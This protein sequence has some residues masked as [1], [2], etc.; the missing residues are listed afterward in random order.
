[1]TS[2]NTN[3][4]AILARTFATKANDRQRTS[5]ERLASGLRINSSADD[6][7]G[8]AVSTKMYSQIT[9]MNSALRNSMDGISLI[10]TAMSGMDTITNMVQRMRELAT[11][12]H[13]GVYTDTDRQNA[14]VEI[15]QLLDGISQI[16]NNTSFNEVSLLDGSYQNSIRAGHTNSE[17]INL[18]IDS[19]GILPFIKGSSTAKTLL[20]NTLLRPLTTASGPSLLDYLS[21]SFSRG[22]SVINIASQTNA[23][24]NSSFQTLENSTAAGASNIDFLAS[25]LATGTSNFITPQ[26]SIGSG[27][28]QIERSLS[29]TGSGSSAF[30]TPSATSG[31]GSSTLDLL[32]S[33]SPTGTSAFNALANSRASGSSQVD[34]LLS[35]TATGTSNFQTPG[36]STATGTTSLDI[37]S[38]TNGVNTSA[39]DTSGSSSADGV[40]GR[41][42]LANANASGN[43][44]LNVLSNS[45]PTSSSSAIAGLAASSTASVT[46]SSRI[47]PLLFENG[48]F[49]YG[50]SGSSTGTG[51]SSIVGW[52]I[53]LEQVNLGDSGQPVTNQIKVNGT[54]ISSPAD[55]GGG[56]DNALVQSDNGNPTTFSFNA[57]SG[58]ITLGTNSVRVPNANGYMHGPYITSKEAY[59]ISAGDQVYFDWGVNANGDAA[60]VYA[61]LVDTATN[62]TV[63]L[64]NYRQSSPGSKSI[65]RQTTTV[66][67]SGNYNFVFVSGSY[68][69]DGGQVLGS[70]L[71]LRDVGITQSNPGAAAVTTGT[72]TLAAQESNSVSIS[73]TQLAEL[74]KKAQLD[75]FNGSFQILQRGSDYNKFSIDQNGNVTSSTLQQSAKSNYSFEV[76]YNKSNGSGYHTETVNLNLTATERA[77]S[78]LVAQEGNNLTINRSDLSLLNSYVNS[79]SGGSF[80]FSSTSANANQFNIDVN[81]GQITS[82]TPLDFDVQKNYSFDV[83]FTRASDGTEFVNT[84][85]LTLTDTLDSVAALTSEEANRVQVANT[86]LSTIL[87]YSN[88]DNQA[89]TFSISGSDGGYFSVDNLGNVT[90]NQALLLATKGTYSFSVNYRGVNGITHTEN[91]TLGLT[92]ALQASSNLTANEATNVTISASKLSK[93][94]GFAARNGPGIYSI[95]QTGSDYN[96]FNVNSSTG[97]ITNATTLDP[98]VQSSYSFDLVF[99]SSSDGRQFIETVNL[100]IADSSSPTTTI[101]SAESDQ[102]TITAGTLLRSVAYATTYGGGAYSLSGS[103]ASK[104]NINSGTGEV[105]SKPG[106]TFRIDSTGVYNHQNQFDFN[107]VYTS[108]ANVH[109]EQIKLKITETLDTVSNVSAHESGQV[110]IAPSTLI[111][112]FAARD[113][114]QGSYQ[115]ASTGPDYAKFSI[116]SSTGNVVSTG[117]L[118][119]DTQPNYTFDVIY[120]SASDGRQFTETV[121]LAITDTLQSTA[122][123]SAEETQSLTIAENALTSTEFFATTKDGA[124]ESGSYNLSGAHAGLFSIAPDGAIT[125]NG[126]VNRGTYNFNVQYTAGTGA[127]HTESV[128]LNV[129]R[130]LQGSSAMSAQEATLVKI[131]KDDLLETRS[132]ATT[133]GSNGTYRFGTSRPDYQFFEFDAF[134]NIQSKAALDFDTQ[135]S[136]V[137]DVIYRASDGREYTDTVTLNLLDTLQSTATLTVEETQSLT[138]AE[139]TLTSTEH[140]ATTKDGAGETGTYALSGTHSNLF[141]V[142]ADGAITSTGTVNK[143]TY[144]FNVNY[145]DGNGVT[146]VEAVTLNVTEALQSSSTLSAAEA[147]TVG[148]NASAMSNLADF[149]SRHSGGSYRLA[150]TGDYNKFDINSSTGRLTSKA[151]LDF[152]TQASYNFDVIYRT[153]V[154]GA[155]TEFTESVTLNLTD[156]LFSDANITAEETQ[157]LTIAAATLSS[158]NAFATK[159]PGVGNYSLTGADANKFSIDGSGNVTSTGTV[160]QGSYNFNVVYTASNGPIHTEAVSLT[161]TEALQGS[162]TITAHEANQITIASNVMS[163]IHSFANRDGFGSYRLGTSGSDYNKFTINASNG[164]IT[165]LGTIEFDSKP[166][167]TFDVIYDGSDGRTFTETVTLNVGDTLNSSASL[168]AEETQSLTIS[169]ATLSST[170]AFATKDPGVGS[171]SLNGTNANLFNIDSNGNITSKNAM[172]RTSGSQYNFNVNYTSSTGKTHSEAVTLTLTEALQSVSTLSAFEANNVVI[173]PATSSYLNAFA[174]RDDFR[175]RYTLQGADVGDFIIS[176]TGVITS[177]NQLEYDNQAQYNIEAIYTASD[178]RIFKDVIT[179]NLKD[180][181]L[182]RATIYAEQSHDV[183]I[184]AAT[185]SSTN[186]FATKDLGVGTYSLTGADSDKF[187]ID[188]SGN[189]T[190]KSSLLQAN[191][192]QYKFNVKYNSST[193]KEHLEE[194]T[195]NLTESLQATATLTVQ[196]SDRVYITSG[197]MEYIQGF[198]QRDNFQGGWRI[199]PSGGDHTQFEISADGTVQSKTPLDFSTQNQYSFQIAYQSGDATREFVQTINLALT[200]TLTGTTTLTAEEGE[201][202]EIDGNVF[203]ATNNHI[204]ANGA[205]GGTYRLD[206]TT[207]DYNEFTINSATGSIRSKGELRL[208]SEENFDLRVIYTRP[209]GVE[210]SETVDMRLTESTF[211]KSRSEVTVS[212]SEVT[213]ISLSELTNINRYSK[214]DQSAGSFRLAADI[215]NTSDYK[216][217]TVDANG[218]IQ[219]SEPLDFESGKTEYNFRLLYDFANQS[220]T[221]EEN[222]KLTV[223]NDL[224]DDNNLN[225]SGID[226]STANGARDA[227]SLLDETIV[228]LSASQAKIGATQNRIQHNINNL[229]N[230]SRITNIANGR[231]IDADFAV[232]TTQLAKESILNNAAAAMLAQANNEKT[233]VLKLIRL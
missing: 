117:A 140:Y 197:A 26:S 230:S 211:N 196:E 72:V 18:L 113:R 165:S 78:N 169:A 153:T 129:T 213:Q 97:Q 214:N 20:S 7:A 220:G 157:S 16:A 178:G 19:M 201:I 125:S 162:S 34:L 200:D 121:N 63:E 193:G 208:A 110:T 49:R 17:T 175:G 65:S 190:S 209:D 101:T 85:N 171:Y 52:D 137:F 154:N 29:T 91:V 51:T 160:T 10:Q 119:F 221:Y 202:V 14:Q 81:N 5:M 174:S 73:N 224:R 194:V 75:G 37:A 139:D 181:L 60:D 170:K 69:A 89:G 62:Q 9:S 132:F 58:Q 226:I 185:L 216:S 21:N 145:T 151:A 38:S 114:N 152:D 198:A 76:R 87:A 47:T 147:D 156:T 206:P 24:G 55:P 57:S 133:D 108:G 11:Q 120:T 1:M 3:T 168:S 86:V 130:A 43:S 71:V 210:F 100:N 182:S 31:A 40:S 36:S 229:F 27:T 92:E 123:L 155:V 177:R 111:T 124:G 189:I 164:N 116:N 232:E 90:S 109:T 45:T 207:E 183:D 84:V 35:N 192:L 64:L 68:D 191:Q 167:L 179:L 98:S 94:Y 66:N 180:T 83:I 39:S 46:S 122:V 61:F 163:S 231:I 70:E 2:I 93:I 138:I 115:I 222:I 103:D 134:N 149:A 74:Y 107:V 131:Y 228:R 50:G 204:T 172:L 15:Q 118:D 176:N 144:N 225:L 33:A 205:S 12:M 219:S 59:S 106:E 212:E 28:S 166:T 135:S 223:T 187:T 102:I 77:T 146:H 104:F 32:G 95:A 148:I 142:A 80:R 8:L 158:T 203:T 150:A 184:A 161:L 233:N 195:L 30:R 42:I 188:S 53:V 218:N 105:T 25:G 217:F 159:D 127:T 44:Y 82:K 112:N 48:D 13:N 79:S 215:G 186:A 141:T 143:G 41:S 227:M 6:A 128:T 96:K 126:T 56:N 136:Y 23:A 54:T 67:S 99:T 173:N 88:E 199:V 4:S 22:S